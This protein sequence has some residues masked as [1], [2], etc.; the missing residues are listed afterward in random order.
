MNVNSGAIEDLL[1]SLKQYF[2]KDN[3]SR[4]DV[5]SKPPLR[6]E[7]LTAEQ[8]EQ[9]ARQLA[10]HHS[11]TDE[12]APEKLLRRLDENGEVL[13]RVTALLHESVREKRPITPAGEWLL[14]N[15]YLIEEEI[16]TGKRYLPKGYSKGLPKLAAGP[17]AGYPRVYDIATE[18][19]CHSDGHVDIHSLSGFIAAYQKVSPL[20]IGELWAIPIMLRLALLENLRRVAARTAIDRIDA[21]LASHWANLIIE[22]VEHKPKD[23]VL[24]IADMARSNPP[25]VSAFIAE[26]ARKLQ[27]KGHDL[28]LP[29]NWIELHL[30]GTSHTI[31]SMVLAEN[32]QQAADQ[33]SVSNSINSLRFLSKMDWREFVET[34]SVVEQSLRLDDFYPDM[35]FQTRDYYRHQVEAIAKRSNRTENDVARITLDLTRRARESGSDKRNHHVG[36]YLIGEGRR[37]TEEACGVSPSLVQSLA[38]GFSRYRKLNYFIGIT[39]LTA[40]TTWLLYELLPPA[41]RHSPYI[42]PFL[43]IF[44]LTGSYFAIAMVN[45]VATIAVLPRPLPRMN[46]VGGVPASARTLVA[47]PSLL[48]GKQQCD[49][50]ARDLEVRYLANRDPNVYFALLTDFADAPREHMPGDEVLMT[51]IKTRITELNRRYGSEKQ[52]PFM[53]FHRWRVYNK[54]DKTWMGHERKRGKL[55]DLNQ[56]LKGGTKTNCSFIIGDERIYRSISYVITL[57]ADTLLPRD[58]A[59]KL[60]GIMAHPLNRPVYDEAMRRIIDGYGVIQPRVAIS[61]HE[62]ERTPFAAMNESDSGI[63][64]YTRV[65]SD[66]YQDVFDEGSFIGKGI[67]D[68]DAFE[69]A[70]G[71]RFP[72][73]R[74]LSHDLLEGSYIRSGFASDV[75]LYEAYPGKYEQ[76]IARRQRWIRGDWQIAAWI[77][78]W[79]PTGKGKREKNPIS[80][81]SRWKIF[82]NLRRSFVTVALTSQFILGWTVME[83]PWLWTLLTLGLMVIPSTANTMRN[84]MRKPKEIDFR[85]HLNNTVGATH[86]TFLQTL[87]T[88][89]CLPYEAL[90]SLSAVLTTLWRIHI[91]KRN[92][93]EWSPSALTLTGKSSFGGTVKRMSIAPLIALALGLL[94]LEYHPAAVPWAA[95]L[96]VV[97]FI[98]PV[99][100]WQISQSRDTRKA[101]LPAD[102]R[103]FLRTTG[104]RTWAFFEQHVT[105]GENWL[106]PDNLQ[107]YPVP[108]IAHRTS[109]TNIS[110]YLL[111]TLTAHDF[112]WLGTRQLVERVTNTFGTLTKMERYKGHLFNW[113]DTQSLVVLRPA[114]ISSVDSGNMAGHLHTLRQGLLELPHQKMISENM[115]TGLKDVLAIIGEVITREERAGFRQFEETFRENFPQRP[116]TVASVRDFLDSTDVMFRESLNLERFPSETEAGFWVHTFLNQVKDIREE[117]RCAAPWVVS[118]PPPQKFASL[119]PDLNEIPTLMDILNSETRWKTVVRSIRESVPLN[120]EE[121]KWLTDFE[122]ARDQALVEAREM[123]T[124]ITHLADQCLHFADIEYEF[125]YDKA[126]R[127]VAIGYNV[128]DR[129]RDTSFYDL[130]ASEARLSNFVAI[131]QGKLPEDSWFALGRRLAS[132]SQSQVLLSWSGS[133]FEY[134]MPML[135]MP[136]YENTLLDETCQAAVDRQIEYGA[137]QDVPWGISESCY[138]LV[139]S[140]LN[141]QYRAFG[142]PGLGFKRGLGQDLVIAPY[143]SVMA[144]M[145]RPQEALANLR[146]IRELGFEGRYG[147]FESIDYTAGRLSRGQ[148]NALIQTFMAHHQGMSLLSIAYVLLD[149]PMQRR[150]EADPGFQASLLLLQEQIPRTT[151]HYESIGDNESAPLSVQTAE[152]RVIRNLDGPVPEVQLLSNGRYHVMVTQAGGGYSR[153]RSTAV[154]RWREDSTCDNWGAFCYVR[155]LETGKYWSSGYQPTGQAAKGYEAIFSQGRAEFRRRD[156]GLETYTEIIV[157]PEDDIEVRRIHLVNHSKSVRH[158]ELTSYSEVV[159]AL[160]VADDAHPAFSN[161]FV[162]TEILRSHQAILCTRRSRSKDEKPPWIFHR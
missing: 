19:I 118:E 148:K 102:D 75:Q 8:M 33:L 78:P 137:R 107:Q 76:D 141:Y 17:Q 38:D 23:L 1:S 21:A 40:A 47:V 59:W 89:A 70:L 69:K 152:I 77:F 32:Q 142:V 42:Y 34:M 22:T 66:V 3:F 103:K 149:R 125:L 124:L 146:R 122:S 63:D 36:Y 4:E 117:L 134:L 108:I 15:F 99:I 130:L 95:P 129:H 72:D 7:L 109:P 143:A 156:Q 12:Q 49:K 61:L 48:T 114:Y 161:L 111:S 9:Y 112:G 140:A 60:A 79:V 138:N 11:I 150:F 132:N 68:V 83:R 144:L 37:Q 18:I 128:D 80:F 41:L 54:R 73:N 158:V 92:L 82:D 85:Q 67:Y 116:L 86:K 145:L 88:L 87:F 28:T 162:Q 131:A 136:T 27:W 106:P 74:I 81:L 5:I 94:I 121:K 44:L 139:D 13:F 31:N 155:D 160:P 133:M 151:G 10:S 110:L 97:W 126:Q 25:M 84:A 135:V 93:L 104:R 29:L 55:A 16:K 96:L 53:L 64:P 90:V 50:L 157:S 35:D 6:S 71:S 58:A 127:L 52:Q 2:Q 91:S 20:T 98:S 39:G 65:T 46:F 51:R 154:T 43:L 45:W 14:D 119:L 105:E 115:L 100:V 123:V 57:D 62:S 30:S 101:T 153:W 24:V 26:F 120:E 147:F 56:F 159:M 113:Y